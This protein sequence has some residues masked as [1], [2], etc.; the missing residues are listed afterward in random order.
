MAKSGNFGIK[1]FF[2]SENLDELHE[3]KFSYY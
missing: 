1:E 3:F 2:G